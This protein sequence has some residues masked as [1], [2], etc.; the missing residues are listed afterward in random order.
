MKNH[1]KAIKT[2]RKKYPAFSD[3]TLEK[4]YL[5]GRLK[6]DSASSSELVRLSF[7]WG[8]INAET[9]TAYLEIEKKYRKE[10]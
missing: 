9:N 1:S 10:D 6:D 4:I 2:F 8:M 5:Y 7:L 3:I